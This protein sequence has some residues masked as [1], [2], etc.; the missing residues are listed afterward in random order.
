MTARALFQKELRECW[1]FSAWAAGIMLVGSIFLLRSSSMRLPEWHYSVSGLRMMGYGSGIEGCLSGFAPLL[2]MIGSLGIALAIRQFV[3]PFHTGEWG[4]LLHRPIPRGRILLI[5][6]GVAALLSLPLVLIWTACWLVVQIP[7]WYPAPTPARILSH[8]LVLLTWGA[9]FY[10][11]V[12]DGALLHHVKPWRWVRWAAAVAAFYL[13]G[14]SMESVAIE[15]TVLQWI[16]LVLL[17]ASI[18]GTFLKREF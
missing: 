2:F 9:V 14:L 5:K 8:G 12:A 17:A 13:F 16:L 15:I 4:F 10:C 18:C 7:G 3:V 1:K 11:A 6:V